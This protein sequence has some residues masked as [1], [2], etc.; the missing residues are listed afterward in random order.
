MNQLVF[1]EQ[2]QAVTDSL[3]VAEVFEKRHDNVL[4]DIRKQAEYAGGDFAA[5]NF[6]ECQYFDKNNRPRPKI[7]LTEDAFTLVAMSYN[8]KEAV[9]MKVKF[10]QEFKRIKEQLQKQF[11]VPTTFS[12]ALRLAADLQERIEL[13]KPKVEAHDK[14]IS[15]D[16]YQKVGQVAKALGIGRNRL[17]AFLRDNKIFMGDNTPYQQFIDRGYFV[18]KEKPITMG[19][20]VINKPQTYVTAKGVDYISRLL[21][22]KIA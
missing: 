20:Q 16:N 5:L 14:F 3:T 15:G 13:D 1:I 7:N 4:S 11:A 8:T 17:F 18:V 2:G 21:D 22:K 10:I 9:Q 19:R 12:E 6:Q